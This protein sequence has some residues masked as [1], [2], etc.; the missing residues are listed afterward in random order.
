MIGDDT[1]D[2]PETW[3]RSRAAML[4]TDRGLA[5]APGIAGQVRVLRG[6]ADALEGDLRA[7]GQL[8][9]RDVR[10]P[11]SDVDLAAVLE[12]AGKRLRRDRALAEA[13]APDAVRAAVVIF[14][15]DPPLSDAVAA[16]VFADLAREA[17]L[18]WA[19]PAD[20]AGLVD[21]D[22]AGAAGASVLTDFATL[23]DDIIARLTGG[24]GAAAAH[25]TAVS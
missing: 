11:V 4:D 9:R 22:L 2:D 18:L 20:L 10:R 12:G 8:T 17:V 15:P 3:D 14:A 21:P 25:G 13:A 23:A 16:R 24:P 7:A 19:V 6:S 5:A 1:A